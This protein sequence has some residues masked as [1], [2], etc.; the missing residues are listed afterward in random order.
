MA[1]ITIHAEDLE[2][3]ILTAFATRGL[4]RDVDAAVAA[5]AIVEAERVGMPEFGLGMLLRA[6]D[7]TSISWAPADTTTDAQREII[8]ATSRFAPLVLAT[9]ARRSAERA[10]AGGIGLTVVTNPGSL[11]RLGPYA[12]VIAGRG[13]VG[14]VAVGSPPLV[15]PVGGSKAALGTNP[16]AAAVPTSTEPVVVDTASS[17]LTR[18]KWQL[19]RD[20]GAPVPPDSAIGA[21]GHP[22][23][24]ASLVTA[25]LPRGGIAGM[26]MALVVEMLTNGVAGIPGSSTDRRAALVLALGSLGSDAELRAVGDD[27]RA[28]LADAGGYVPGRRAAEAPSEVVVDSDT[29]SRIVHVK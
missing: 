6:L 16:L 11:G 28:R 21:D 9:A 8:D 15:A 23:S 4:E 2:A 12:R 20:E 1:T 19:L 17:E 18:G 22:V 7:S 5:R 3:G 10:T 14:L 13:L 27:L 25:F 29:W 26:T 24:D